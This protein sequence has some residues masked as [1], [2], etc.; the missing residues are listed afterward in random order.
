MEFSS[1]P[2]YRQQNQ[3]RYRRKYTIHRNN[4]PL[5]SSRKENTCIKTQ[6]SIYSLN[7]V[8]IISSHNFVAMECSY[9]YSII[10]CFVF[11]M[12][13][14]VCRRSLGGG[15]RGGGGHIHYHNM[16][17]GFVQHLF[18]LVFNFLKV[19]FRLLDLHVVK[20]RNP[21]RYVHLIYIA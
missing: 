20:T 3:D 12:L 17:V 9:N 5:R 18:R 19:D 6:G 16:N 14:T 4:A 2:Y 21:Y 11:S 7:S 15:M 8:E 1:R 10:S 13:M